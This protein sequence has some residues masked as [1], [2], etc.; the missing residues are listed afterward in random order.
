MDRNDID[1]IKN[2]CA[3]PCATFDRSISD[4][5]TGIGTLAEIAS[6]GSLGVN[7][8]RAMDDSWF[9]AV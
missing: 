6:S 1:V 9:V 4:C 5:V 3:A 7:R 2:S 8:G